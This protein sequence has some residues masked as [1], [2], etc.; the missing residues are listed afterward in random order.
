MV[1]LAASTGLRV[2]EL[3]GLKWHDIDFTTLEIRLSR[4]V[5]DGVVGTM[6]T[7]ASCKPIALDASLADVL[8]DR[9][10]LQHIEGQ[11]D[12]LFASPRMRG[13]KPYSPDSLLSKVT[14]PA[15]KRAG[16]IKRVGWHTFRH[17]FATLLKVTE[18]T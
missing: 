18:R 17:T 3:I 6:K 14:R 5:V 8:L 15:A 12:W 2:S 13:E 7:E 10:G 1:F 11:A 9:R 4:G 16:I